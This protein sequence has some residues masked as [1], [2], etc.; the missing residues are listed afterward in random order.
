MMSHHERIYAKGHLCA[1]GG[2]AVNEATRI[3]TRPGPSRWTFA[4][5]FVIRQWLTSPRASRVVLTRYNGHHNVYT[6]EKSDLISNSNPELAGERNRSRCPATPHIVRVY[7][8]LHG[9][10]YE[11]GE[12]NEKKKNICIYISAIDEV[13]LCGRPSPDWMVINGRIMRTQIISAT[14]LLTCEHTAEY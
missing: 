13:A 14:W 10:S 3:R 8:N 1:R 9:V 7:A 6:P 4:S 11:P 12:P 5:R 2:V